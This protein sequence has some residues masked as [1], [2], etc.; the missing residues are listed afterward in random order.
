MNNQKDKHLQ[1]PEDYLFV[2][3]FIKILAPVPTI[4]NGGT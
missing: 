2:Q 3:N 4:F 1:T